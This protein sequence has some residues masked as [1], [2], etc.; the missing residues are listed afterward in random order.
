MKKYLIILLLFSFV[1]QTNKIFAI[2]CDECSQYASGT[3]EYNNCIN[4]CEEE[5]ITESNSYPKIQCGDTKVPYVAAQ[6]TSTIVLAIQ[7]IVPVIIILLGM[8]DFAKAVMAQKEDEIK[9]GSQTF[10]KRLFIGICVF[11]VFVLIKLIISIPASST[12]NDSAWD[13]VDCFINKS[14]CHIIN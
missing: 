1:F 11:L 8:L 6:I 7:V 3:T 5:I 9:K 4:N 13:C 2:S 14:N 12:M 10:F